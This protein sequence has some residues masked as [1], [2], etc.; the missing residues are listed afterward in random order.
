MTSNQ[1]NCLLW[2]NNLILFIIFFSIPMSAEAQTVNDYKKY[3][4]LT[5]PYQIK[6]EEGNYY[7]LVSSPFLDADAR[8]GMILISKA[9]LFKFLKENDKNLTSIDIERFTPEISWENN[10]RLFL[11]SIVN[12]K[13][14]K[15][16]YNEAY[17]TE[18]H[19]AVLSEIKQLVSIPQKNKDIHERLKELYF[20]IG[21]FDNYNKE[22]DIIMDIIFNEN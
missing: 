14:I 10:G 7:I 22:V 1:L 8:R 21:D 19:N 3:F 18:Y 20:L 15:R 13:N 4:D 5:K 11:V 9:I 17:P 6:E 16:Y 12:K 2:K